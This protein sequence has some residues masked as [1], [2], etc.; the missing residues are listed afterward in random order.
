MQ[1]TTT[2]ESL[3]GLYNCFED[4]AHAAAIVRREC[5]MQA[6]ARISSGGLYTG[7]MARFA[8]EVYAPAP[9]CFPWIE[10]R[11]YIARQ[12]KAA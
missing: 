8:V 11:A 12:R 7:A 3:A 4:A 1:T 10:L 2:L 9:F 5:G 6:R